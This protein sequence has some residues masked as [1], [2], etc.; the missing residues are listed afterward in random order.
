MTFTDFVAM[1][2]GVTEEEFEI[3]FQ[4]STQEEIRKLWEQDY[5]NIPY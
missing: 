4:K 5:K 2:Y 3:I 1:K